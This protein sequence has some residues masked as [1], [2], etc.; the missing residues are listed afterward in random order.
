[1]LHMEPIEKPSAPSKEPPR[2]L[3]Q[4]PASYL[5]LGGVKI[6]PSRVALPMPWALGQD[7]SW[8]KIREHE[9]TSRCD[10]L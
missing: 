6:L 5:H 3:P 4:P 2:S 9:E 10:D 1:M 8:S 7:G